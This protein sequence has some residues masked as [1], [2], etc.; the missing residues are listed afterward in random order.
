MQINEFMQKI[1]YGEQAVQTFYN[2]AVSENEYEKAKALYYSNEQKFLSN[3]KKMEKDNYYCKLVYYFT[4]FALE[5]YPEYINRGFTEQ[6]YIHT[7]HD[8]AIWNEMCM[9]ETGICGLRET[10]WLT[11]HL[12]CGIV[13]LGRVQFQPEILQE[14]L[15]Y[16]GKTIARGSEILHIHVPFGGALPINEVQDSLNRARKHFNAQY[17]HAESWLLDP[18]LKKYLSPSSNI[19]AFAN[20]FELYKTEQSDSIERFVFKVIKKDK[21]EYEATNRFQ[22]DIKQALMQGTVFYSGYGVLKLQ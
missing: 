17:V 9:L 5:L 14:D 3:L 1:G 13:R 19:L 2:Q 11:S 6:E 15:I 10:H 18:T 20:L 16:N 22:C 8:L 4:R 7:F 21:K 12:H